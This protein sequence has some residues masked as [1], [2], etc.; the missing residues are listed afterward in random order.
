MSQE[1]GEAVSLSTP[2]LVTQFDLLARAPDGVARLRALILALAVRG[3]LVPQDSREDPARL[4]VVVEQVLQLIADGKVPKSRASEPL[5]DRSDEWELPGGWAAVR[6]SDVFIPR[7][8]NSKLIKGKLFSEPGEGL[9]AGYSASG[10]D[11]WLSSFEYDGT[12]VILSAVGARCG[13][14]FLARGKWSAIANTHIV[15]PIEGVVS[16]D[17]AML[18][19]ND[20]NFWIRSGGAQPFLKVTET[21][22]RTVLIPPLREQARIVARVDEL[23]QLCDALE[24]KGRLEAQQHARLLETLLGTL[25]DSTTPEEL[26]ANWQCV[27]DHFDL[28]LDRPGAV[29]ALE[30]TILQLAVRG[31][32][33]RQEDGVEPAGRLLQ[34]IREE[35]ARTLSEIQ[36]SRE[37]SPQPLAES[38][39]A[40]EAPQGW[41][42]V[43]LSQ[44]ADFTNGFAFASADFSSD[45]RGVGVVKIGDLQNGEVTTASMSYVSQQLASTIRSAFVVSPGDLL[46]AMSGATTGKLALNRSEKTFLLNQRVG[47]I[48]PVFV[49]RDFL[50]LCLETK[51]AENLA[52]S[53][54]SAIPNLSTAQIKDIVVALPPVQE[55]DR[56][57]ARVTALRHLCAHLR[58]RLVASQ[59]TQSRLAEALVDQ[60]A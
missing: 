7:S 3:K 46:I 4:E 6:G 57:V 8:G 12:A 22:Q 34:R 27:A 59:A 15:W 11:V 14:A 44:I 29:D 53:S 17:Y 52:I 37:Q 60:V 39:I 5:E 19:L 18:L 58:Q 54:G 16:G 50:Y 32:L 49:N 33:V 13:K 25:T 42:W 48:S 28:L 51:I 1:Q 26:A 30:K 45:V 21:L 31:L 24:A 55:Q 38:D 41:E 10:Q 2:A 47:K 9:Y 43:R 35:K 56:I 40:L 20:E 23:M 36:L